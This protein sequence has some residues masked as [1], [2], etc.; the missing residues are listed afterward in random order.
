MLKCSKCNK[1]AEYYFEENDKIIYS[2]REHAREFMFENNVN[3]LPRIKVKHDQK[4]NSNVLTCPYLI[5]GILGVI[6][7]ISL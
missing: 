2:C 1:E 6:G 7:N 5:F 4:S 3:F